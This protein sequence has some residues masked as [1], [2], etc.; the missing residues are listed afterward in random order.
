[1]N[2]TIDHTGHVSTRPAFQP[3]DKV[4]DTETG[5]LYTV[6]S[7]EDEFGYVAFT[8]DIPPVELIRP[9]FIEPVEVATVADHEPQHPESELH[10][11]L[12]AWGASERTTVKQLLRLALNT[13]ID[14]AELFNAYA[15]LGFIEN[16]GK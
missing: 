15:S 9:R 3:G 2:N 12:I 13:D 16:G 10:A 1:M 4:R 5:D 6:V 7:S 8:R 14:V 11:R